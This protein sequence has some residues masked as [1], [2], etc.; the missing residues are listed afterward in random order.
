M[1]S[2][3]KLFLTEDETKNIQSRQDLIKQYQYLIHVI[4]ADIQAYM[5][6]QVLKRLAVPE[7]KNYI[8]STDN[9]FITLPGGEDE[10]PATEKKQ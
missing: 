7:G 9:T 6:Y 1:K 3:R 5:H 2:P 10:R 4:N 8:L